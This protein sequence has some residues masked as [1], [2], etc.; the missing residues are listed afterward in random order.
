[1]QSAALFV[2]EIAAFLVS[3]QLD[4]RPLRQGR[5]I[6]EH[7]PPI[8]GSQRA[9]AATVRLSHAPDKRSHRTVS[10]RTAEPVDLL[11]PDGLR[12]RTS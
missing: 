5:R 12:H 4:N 8:A 3:N 6:V 10:H 2:R 11:K 7:E 1:M 9:H